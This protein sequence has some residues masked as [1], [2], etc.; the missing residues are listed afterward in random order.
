M[1]SDKLE[2]AVEILIIKA[3]ETEKSEDAMC[4]SQAACNAAS[5][6]RVLKEAAKN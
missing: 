1:T 5:A 2:N 3:A 6:M 4:F